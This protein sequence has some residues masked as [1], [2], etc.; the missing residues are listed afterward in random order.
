[1]IGMGHV[2]YSGARQRDPDH[3]GTDARQYAA[4]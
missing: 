4:A 1:V 2:P 3:T